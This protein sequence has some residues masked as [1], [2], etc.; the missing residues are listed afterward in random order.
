MPIVDLAFPLI[1]TQPIPADHGYHLHGALSRIADITFR[2][3][4][5]I[6]HRQP[7]VV[8]QVVQQV[9]KQWCNRWCSR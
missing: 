4:K 8:Q 6:T 1:S 3:R 9:V 2:R 7:T 5:S